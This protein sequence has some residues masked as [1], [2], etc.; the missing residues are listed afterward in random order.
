[1]SETLSGRVQ[2]RKLAGAERFRMIRAWRALEVF[3]RRLKRGASFIW[4]ALHL[5]HTPQ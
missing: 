2:I 3:H 4:L 1:L 5:K